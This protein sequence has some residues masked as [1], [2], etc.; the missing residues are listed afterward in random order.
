MRVRACVCVH[1]CICVCVLGSPDPPA[2]T[3]GDEARSLDFRTLIAQNF[4]SKIAFTAG[5]P[6]LWTLKKLWAHS[7]RRE[8]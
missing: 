5:R 8:V 2:S 4:A 6:A 1:A 7:P 3:L